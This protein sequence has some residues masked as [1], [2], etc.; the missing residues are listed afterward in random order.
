MLH[1]LCAIFTEHMLFS[2]C[3]S[4][5]PILFASL[6]L[7]ASCHNKTSRVEHTAT[8]LAV[9]SAGQ[10]SSLDVALREVRI[11]P[12]APDL[13]HLSGNCSCKTEH[14]WDRNVGGKLQQSLILP[15]VFTMKIFEGRGQITTSDLPKGRVTL[16]WVNPH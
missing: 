16:L 12:N 2:D 14:D 8:H 15:N 13:S 11:A 6:S 7:D 1:L 9:A 4:S 3:L 5:V 10:A